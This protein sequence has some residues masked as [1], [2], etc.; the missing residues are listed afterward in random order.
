MLFDEGLQCHDQRAEVSL[1]VIFT[2]AAPQFAGVLAQQRVQADARWFGVRAS[3]GVTSATSESA[4][5]A[6]RSSAPLGASTSLS[7]TL[8]R[9][10]SMTPRGQSAPPQTQRHETRALGW[11]QRAGAIIRAD[12][13][14]KGIAYAGRGDKRIAQLRQHARRAQSGRQRG[15]GHTV[16][17]GAGRRQFDGQRQIAQRIHNCARHRRIAR[18]VPCALSGGIALAKERNGSL[19]SR[20]SSR[21]TRSPGTDGSAREVMSA[22]T[23]SAFRVA[24]ARESGSPGSTLS[25]SANAASGSA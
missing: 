22:R 23:P 8:S 6:S 1:A 4:T 12:G 2:L 14:L 21:L 15:D 17:S 16:A 19:G 25:S 5:S 9:Y 11:R 13:L 20:T 24:S 18:F 7:L 3:R 10:A